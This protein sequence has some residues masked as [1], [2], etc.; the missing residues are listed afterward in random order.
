M[1]EEWNKALNNHSQATRTQT[2]KD[3]TFAHFHEMTIHE[4]QQQEQK[5]LDQAT[6]EHQNPTLHMG[7]N[8]TKKAKLARLRPP[9]AGGNL[10]AMVD[11]EGKI[12]TETTEMADLLH[13]HWSRTFHNKDTNHKHTKQWLKAAYEEGPPCKAKPEDWTPRRKDMIRAI[14][15]ANASAPG[16]DGIPYAAWKQ[17]GEGAINILWAALR[18]INTENDATKHYPD[19]NQ[20]ILVCSPKNRRSPHQTGHRHS[21]ATTH[22]HWPSPTRT[23]VCWLRR[24]GFVGK[25]LLRTRST[26]INAAFY[27]VGRCSPTSPK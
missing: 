6:K 25:G 8:N 12:I 17:A 3:L 13:N 23:T 1:S 4:A 10:G 24:A 21:T 16:P 9:G 26:N 18:T 7:K 14:R 11:D 5:T 20:A 19:F 2:L 15:I 27:Q 22:D